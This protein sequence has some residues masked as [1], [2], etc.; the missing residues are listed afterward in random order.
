MREP[1]GLVA[2]L[3]QINSPAGEHVF[4]DLIGMSVL[5]TFWVVEAVV[6]GL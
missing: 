4:L 5:G 3:G 2:H 6:L 1:H